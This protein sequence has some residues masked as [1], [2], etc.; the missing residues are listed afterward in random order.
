[1]E[2]FISHDEFYTF[3]ESP[4]KFCLKS[5]CKIGLLFCKIFIQCSYGCH[6]LQIIQIYTEVSIPC[7]IIFILFIFCN[8]ANVL[9]SVE[10]ENYP[11]IF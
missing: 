2:P 7:R 10:K 4:T 9:S 3:M 6:A 1:M 11:P 5:G 8:L